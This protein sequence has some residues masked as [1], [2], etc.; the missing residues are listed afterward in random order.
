MAEF[1]HY[2]VGCMFGRYS[3]DELVPGN[4]VLRADIFNVFNLRAVTE[5]WEYG[6]QAGGAVDENYGKP[7]AYQAGRSV[8]L[9]FDWSF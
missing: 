7:V 9:G 8:R 5:A 4:L 2:A 1:L 3:L 6:E